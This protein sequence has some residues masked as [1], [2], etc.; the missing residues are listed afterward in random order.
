MTTKTNISI[1]CAG[2][3]L[4]SLALIY[5]LIYPAFKGIKN[6]YA[7]I[8][9][10]KTATASLALQQAAMDDFKNKQEA[11]APDLQK[12]EAAFV[13]PQNPVEFIK[14]LETLAADSGISADITIALP[15]KSEEAR[16][17]RVAFQVLAKGKFLDL[18]EFGEKL[19]HGQYLAGINQITLRQ[20]GEDTAGKKIADGT[21]EA[22]F[23]IEAIAK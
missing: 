3:L 1:W 11:Y 13:D 2:F 15:L 17:N 8:L 7:Q 5:G 21:V 22:T 4:I 10:T 14:F 23:L 6:A 18:L 9:E 12:L 19:E 16:P 20:A